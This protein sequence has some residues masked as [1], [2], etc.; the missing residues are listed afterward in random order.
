MI[1]VALNLINRRSIGIPE[2]A[3]R[4]RQKGWRRAHQ[5]L[6]F[7]EYC[8]RCTQLCKFVIPYASHKLRK[9]TLVRGFRSFPRLNPSLIICWSIRSRSCWSRRP[10]ILIAVLRETLSSTNWFAFQFHR[11]DLS[12]KFRCNY[13]SYY[14]YYKRYNLYYLLLRIWQFTTVKS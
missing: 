12:T 5:R 1:Y 2:S 4:I 6:D 9:L 7:L 3:G 14:Y 11:S 8:M 10:R 13:D